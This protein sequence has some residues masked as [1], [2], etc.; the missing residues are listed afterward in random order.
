[1]GRVNRAMPPPS[2]TTMDST[3]AKIGRLM[4]N[5]ENTLQPHFRSTR[6][7]RL[8]S[9]LGGEGLGVRGRRSGVLLPLTPAP[10]P[11]RGEGGPE[12]NLISPRCRSRPPDFGARP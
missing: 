5:F 8:P 11:P 1:M 2:T 3:E 6:P 9:P 12:Q 7:H 4:K 10:S